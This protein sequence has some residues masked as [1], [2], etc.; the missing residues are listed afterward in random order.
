M[1]RA[2]ARVEVVTYNAPL[3]SVVR[4]RECFA[5]CLR[6]VVSPDNVRPLHPS[7]ILPRSTSG[8]GTRESSLYVTCGTMCVERGEGKRESQQPRARVHHTRVYYVHAHPISPLQVWSLLDATA[9][10]PVL[11]CEDQQ[12]PSAWFLDRDAALDTL[13]RWFIQWELQFT[14]AGAFA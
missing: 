1:Q 7:L 6:G 13:L 3:V 10:L 11:V 12:Q 4:M 2:T 9:V 8:C 5:M 14:S